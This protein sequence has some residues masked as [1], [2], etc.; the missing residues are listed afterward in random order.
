MSESVEFS[1]AV[2]EKRMS[3]AEK[4]APRIVFIVYETNWNPWHADPNFCTQPYVQNRKIAHF[5]V[6]RALLLTYSL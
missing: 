6:K 5:H 1:V 4:R 3:C 2:R